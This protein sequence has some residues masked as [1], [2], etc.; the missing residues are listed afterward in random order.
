MKKNLM[1]A[2]ALVL[3]IGAIIAG[4]KK[5][6]IQEPAPSPDCKK[7]T[8][9][10]TVW[11]SSEDSIIRHYNNDVADILNN[12]CIT[13]HGGSAPSA[14]LLLTNYASAKSTAQSGLL[15]K[16]LNDTINPMPPAGLLPQD[17]RDIVQKW[18]DDGLL[19]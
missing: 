15:T 12:Y 18:I 16:R 14:G 19:E 13:C 4:C 17:K 6:E 3:V 11:V 9:Y 1:K 5:E 10:D 2:A 7:V 8:V